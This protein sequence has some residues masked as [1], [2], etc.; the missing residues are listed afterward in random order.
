MAFI[1]ETLDSVFGQ[2]FTDLEVVVND[3]SPDTDALERA[4]ARIAIAIG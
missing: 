3:E 1:G 4:L 2:T